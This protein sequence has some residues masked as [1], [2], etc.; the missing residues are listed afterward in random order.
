VIWVCFRALVIEGCINITKYDFAICNELIMWSMVINVELDKLL[1]VMNKALF[2][3]QRTTR[4][5]FIFAKGRGKL[6]SWNIIS[7]HVH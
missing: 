2:I 1:N 5:T 4:W 6:V 3:G 7:E